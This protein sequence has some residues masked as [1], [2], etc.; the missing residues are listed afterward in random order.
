MQLLKP[1]APWLPWLALLLISDGSMGRLGAGLLVALVAGVVLAGM[2]LYRGVLMWAGLLFFT[3]AL[4]AVFV[5]RS[6]WFV[7]HLAVIANAMLAVGAWGSLI[8]GRPF[9]V[10]F[11]REQTDPS[12]WN[13]PL[14][15][16]INRVVTA[17]WAV[18]F[19]LN[20]AAAWM[21]GHHLLPAWAAY[22]VPVST[23]LAA[24]LFSSWY[25]RHARE[26]APD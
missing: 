15:I 18:V 22:A 10:N 26:R 1:L 7:S 24:T 25:P 14:F 17:L 12:R 6:E 8:L 13:D 11:A 2:K 23:L 20:A 5:F 19:T 4:L 21:Q 16:R 3:L 9:T